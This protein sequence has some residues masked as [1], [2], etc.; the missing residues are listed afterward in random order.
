[1]RERYALA[2]PPS[3]DA[4]MSH[5]G[6][7]MAHHVPMAH[8]PDGAETEKEPA[9]SHRIESPDAHT[10]DAIDS[11]EL[12]AAPLGTRFAPRR[13]RPFRPSGASATVRFA[14]VFLAALA[15]LVLT[16]LIFATTEAGQI[17]E[18][19][20][21]RGAEFRSEA[22]REAA[23]GRLS[24]VT[25]AIFALA[26]VA[27][28][29]VGFLRRREPLALIAAATMVGAVVLAEILKGVLPRPA[30]VEGPIW[31]LRPSFPSGSAA[32]AAAIAIGGLMVAPDRLR[33][34]ALTGGVVFAGLIVEAVQA[35]GWHR[36][37]DTIGGVLLVIVVGSAGLVVLA[38]AGY[39]VPS[40]AARIDRRIR[41][42]LLV[43]AA[44]AVI[45][46]FALAI[47]PVIFPLLAAPAGARRS[48]LQTAFP[49]V[50]IGATTAAIVVFARVIEPY[51]LGRRPSKDD[52]AA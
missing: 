51:S 44:G 47:L 4:G 16:Y 37:S 28:V 25:V 34:V 39:V 1:M 13:R 7:S 19:L 24:V 21:L 40:E 46:G 26:V 11:T 17:V 9:A 6:T 45:L 5:A 14:A 30:L 12:P 32:V 23:L 15:L 8:D 35:T 20:A 2:S 3:T 43:V 50:G 33:W 52:P 18:N 41:V 10:V 22:D 49:L 29:S 36:L 31:L 42:A 38:R 27:V 48:I